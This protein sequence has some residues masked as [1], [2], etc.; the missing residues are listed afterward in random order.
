KSDRIQSIRTPPP[1]PG[2]GRITEAR[3]MPS[4]PCAWTGPPRL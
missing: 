2:R 4:S 3:S 1:R